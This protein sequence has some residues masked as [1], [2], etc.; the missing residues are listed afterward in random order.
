MGNGWIFTVFPAYPLYAIL[1]YTIL[2]YTYYWTY[3]NVFKY[4]MNTSRYVQY[5]GMMGR[6]STVVHVVLMSSFTL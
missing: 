2:Y 3:N 1:Y 6:Y 4:L 5:D